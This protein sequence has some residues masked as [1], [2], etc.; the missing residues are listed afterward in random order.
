MQL[1]EYFDFH[2][3]PVEHI[4]IKGT[5]IGLEDVVERY[6]SGIHPDRIAADY[7]PVLTP[8]QVYAALTYYHRNKD[9]VEAYFERGNALY[10]A[11]VREA[12]TRPES[13]AAARVQAIKAAWVSATA[14]PPT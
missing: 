8:E 13:D 9:A 2:T 4:R 1:E 7:A 5:R 10:A 3:E 14:G 11:F 6:R 12:Q